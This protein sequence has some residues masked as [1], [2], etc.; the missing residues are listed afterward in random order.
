MPKL[1]KQRR[2]QKFMHDR[3]R[4]RIK[5]SHD[6]YKKENIKVTSD[7][8][9]EHWDH[10]E[11]IQ[12]NLEKMGVAF[13]ANKV[14]SSQKSTKEQYVEKIK[15][16]S[17]EKSSVEKEKKEEPTP[18]KSASSLVIKRLEAEAAEAHANKKQTFRF[19][20]EQVRWI[21]FCMDKHGDDFKAMAKDPKNIWQE[22]P[23]QIRQKVMKFISI[24]EH[25]DVYA[26]ERGLQVE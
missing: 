13:D 22:T 20:K 5:K 9:K 25:F 19:P 24:P 10:K 26:N 23:K 4:K 3:N 7:V 15:E 21:T 18:K 12:N 8:M 14:I 17:S 16:T 11:S 6:K 2:R 1:R